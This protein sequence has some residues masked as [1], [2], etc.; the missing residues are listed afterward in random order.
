M[1]IVVANRE[2]QVDYTEDPKKIEDSLL[3]SGA[4]FF[5]YDTE[6]TGLHIKK[7]RPFIG[8]VC[9]KDRVWVFPATYDLLMAVLKLA[10]KVERVWGHNVTFDMHM[11]ANI[12]GDEPVLAVKNWGD[13]MGLL[14]LVY[15]AI[16]ERDGGDRLGLKYFGVK[17]VDQNVDQYEKAVK[18]WL[19]AKEKA[20]R[21]V[22]IAFLRG[23]RDE[24]GIWTM[25]RFQKALDEGK[26]PPQ[27]LE[28]YNQWRQN[29]PKPTYRDVPLDIMLPYVAVDVILTQFAVEKAMPVIEYKQ[30]LPT[31]EREFRVLPVVW[32]M[33]RA[34][35]KVDRQYLQE[36]NA[37]LDEYIQNLYAKLHLLTG[38]EFSVYQQKVIKK[39]YTDILGE[40][41]KSVD[42]R[43]L[44]KM[45]EKG[46]EVA[47]I[48][49]RL[50]RLEKWK[51]TYVE[52]ILEV[53]EYDGRFYT[54][55]NQ[56]GP[57]SGRFSSD[58]QQFP[59]DPIYTEEGY[60]F[61]K[62][63]PNQAVPEEYVLFHPRKAFQGR[64]FYFDYSQVELRVQAH[65]T[66]YFGGDLNLCRAYMPYR[67]T[68]YKT[69]EVFDHTTPEH[70]ARWAELREGAPKDLHWEDALKQ[71][72]SA[73][74]N[75]DTGKP[76][77]PTDVHMATTLKALVAMGHDPN[78]MDPNLLQWWRKKGKQFNFMRNYGGGDKKA[79]EILDI[80]LEQAHALNQGFTEAFP[81]VVT[82]QNNVIHSARA[83][84]YVKNMYGRR[85]YLSDWRRH[86][87]LA[88]Y[89]IQGSCAD[90]L[91]EKMIEID[92]FLTK[93]NIPWS[94]FRMILCVHDEIQFE[95]VTR[96]GKHDWVIP[97]IKKIMEN[98]PRFLVPIVAEIEMT[99]TNWAEQKPYHVA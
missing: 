95:D 16:S 7:D 97:E 76:W 74:I 64:I 2:F 73:W 98:T 88:N 91:K 70:R 37:K 35:I 28:V 49:N 53:S 82:Y 59:K 50:R 12:V 45:S 8:A 15:E 79:A 38:I 51:A 25:K 80:T 94:E 46:D 32:K 86:Y 68:H 89:L 47:A 99:E 21:K 23:I 60:A 87:K 93:H 20:N 67:C 5:T 54:Q 58:A 33:E 6:S 40:E 96:T 30:Q 24:N 41:P 56:F 84:G 4:T 10:S 43:F 34:G 62:D 52:R 81:L 63:H 48:I 44:K 77:E 26:L 72:W 90:M 78:E 29:Y 39:I 75:P 1:K 22:L 92:E 27:V 57:V 55:F 18:A 66:L 36:C 3:S 14:R 65:Y 69:G 85:Y 11:T 83:K 61:E 13:T 42:K 9:F 17:Y 31:L 71:G 19:E